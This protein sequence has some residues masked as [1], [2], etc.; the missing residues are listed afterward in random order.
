MK[1][2]IEQAKDNNGEKIQLTQ[3]ELENMITA[4][5]RTAISEQEDQEKNK[6]PSIKWFK[7][8]WRSLTQ[9]RHF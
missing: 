2:E 4:A 6:N 1:K 8:K 3:I 5:I 9:L 7:K